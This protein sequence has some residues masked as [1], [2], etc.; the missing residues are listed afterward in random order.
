MVE[1]L[2]KYACCHIRQAAYADGM[3]PHMGGGYRFGHS[4]HAYG[5]GTCH[6]Y[7]SYF[8]RSFEGWTGEEHIDTFAQSDAQP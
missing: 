2:V 6:T 5:I 3:H 8:G 7:E 4:G 1:R